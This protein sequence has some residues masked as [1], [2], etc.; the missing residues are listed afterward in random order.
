MF[1]ITVTKTGVFFCMPDKSISIFESVPL[2]CILPRKFKYSCAYL[3][4]VV[5]VLVQ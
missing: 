2:L 5:N 3:T 1:L 4:D